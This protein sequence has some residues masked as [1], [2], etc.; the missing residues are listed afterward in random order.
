MHNQ[1]ASLSSK[2]RRKPATPTEKAQ[3]AQQQD[4]ADRAR[5]SYPKLDRTGEYREKCVELA[6]EVGANA[7]HVWEEFEERA[8]VRWYL[9][10]MTRDAAEELAWGDVQERW[11]KTS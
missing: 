9:G 10:V 7:E 4:R 8:S 3:L 11:S 6:E 1:G 2:P 5:R